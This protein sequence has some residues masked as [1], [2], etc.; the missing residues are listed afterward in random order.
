MENRARAIVKLAAKQ[1]SGSTRR[2]LTMDERGIHERHAAQL[3][4]STKA[5][6]QELGLTPKQVDEQI[7]I[8]IAYEAVEGML[9]AAKAA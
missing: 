2:W 7:A 6:A 9:K 4:E 8:V 3:L 1:V 5:K